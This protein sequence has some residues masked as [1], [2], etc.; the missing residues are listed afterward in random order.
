[1]RAQANAAA[2]PMRSTPG[3]DHDRISYLHDKVSYPHD[4]TWRKSPI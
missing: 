1:M 4:Q 3:D 2:R